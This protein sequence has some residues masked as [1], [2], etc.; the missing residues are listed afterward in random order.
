MP[1]ADIDIAEGSKA[2]SNSV[3]MTPGAIYVN[4]LPRFEGNR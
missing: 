3:T 2:G 1:E 4:N